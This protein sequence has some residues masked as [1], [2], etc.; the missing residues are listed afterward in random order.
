[1][2]HSGR[3]PAT[4]GLGLRSASPRI[5]R[6]L[7]R[8]PPSE[9]D[10]ST[11]TGTLATGSP[12]P[13]ARPMDSL[14]AFEQA[15]ALHA[16]G[17]LWEADQLYQMVLKA[18]RR[19]FGALCRVGAIRLQQGRFDDAVALFRRALKVDG[20]SADAHQGLAFALTGLERFED[21]VRHYEKALTIRPDFAEARNNLGHALQR[22]GRFE[23]AIGQYEKALAVDPA[24]AEAHNNIG[25][26]LN[27]LGRDDAAIAHYERAIAIRPDYAAAYWNL[28]NAVR[29]LGR[30]Q[31]AIAHYQKALAIRPNYPEAH[32]A[33]GNVLRLLARSEDAIVHYENALA[34][35]PSYADAH[36][37]LGAALAV[38]GSHD[39]A[40]ARYDKALAIR[41]EDPDALS[42]RGDSLVKLK[43]HDEAMASY[44]RAL[45]ADPDRAPAFNGLTDAAR[46]ACDW[47]RTAKL[48]PEAVRRVTA[49]KLVQPFAFLGYCDDPSLQL[50]CARNFAAH[51]LP[52][53]PPR[54]FNGGVWRN[55]RIRVAYL[56]ADFAV[57]PTAYLIAELFELHDRSRFEVLGFSL[58]A[59]DRSDIR[60]RIIRGFDRFY[61]I[62]S[63]NDREAA[64]L[65]NDLQVDVVVDLSAYTAGCRPGILAC[66]P[67][68]IQVSYLVFPGTTGAAHIDYLIA[69]SIVLP[70]DQQP[71]YTESIVR[72]P[73]CYQVNDGKR[74]IGQSPTRWELGMP[75]QG[76]VF[77]CF[78]NNNKLTAP[79]FDIWMRL[80]Q[81]I[82][83]SVFWLYR[84]SAVAERNLRK[85]AAAR[86]MDPARLIFADRVEREQHLAR[87]RTADLFLDTLPYNAH[88][89]ASDA[90]WAG[91]PLVTCRGNSFAGRV[92]AS[93]L[94]AVGLPE[95]VTNSLEG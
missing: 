70:F 86:G 8:S 26:A 91:L 50:R 87:H 75:D 5:S 30:F 57:H 58:G 11:R 12:Q 81:R 14:Q 83:G 56:S 35:K 62:R 49:G 13:H 76:F 61:D 6:T 60:A 68:P 52:A 19:H 65:I 3:V 82:E 40:I 88:T 32:N 15:A 27:L 33:I 74:L 4:I 67:A 20:T 54:L 90:L 94:H 48:Y 37:N 34:L 23:A 39:E 84:G 89:T 31:E 73:D 51:E 80:L 17:R 77:C 64:K 18:D 53:A 1:M 69:D 55:Q 45:V 71:F 59:D 21:A 92:A 79:I 9:R 38:I 25:N 2:C 93:L 78:N 16:L 22:L 10:S 95:L 72:L 42:Q 47:A 66:R 36:V 44:E 85:E 29:A 24:Y 63:T 28:G 43:R 7:Q 41:P 46:T